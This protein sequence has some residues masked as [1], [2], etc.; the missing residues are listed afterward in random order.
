M[1]RQPRTRSDK[2]NKHTFSQGFLEGV[3]GGNALHGMMMGAV[4][5]I[6]GHYIDKYQKTPGRGGE[7]A[8]SAVLGGTIDVADI[9]KVIDSMA[10][11]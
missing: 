4:S 11:N 9:A 2:K 1:A 5:G 7:I 3:Q 10:K 6:G 8:A